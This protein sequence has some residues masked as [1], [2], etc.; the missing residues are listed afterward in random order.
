MIMV[1][2]LVTILLIL[3]IILIIYSLIKWF[4][5][6]S[7]AKKALQERKKLYE[8]KTLDEVDQKKFLE[9]T[10]NKSN[11]DMNQTKEGLLTSNTKM[12]QDNYAVSEIE[13]NY[14]PTT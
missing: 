4:I 14:N 9:N 6:K 2:V 10:M 7:G 11:P 5:E 13:P 1:T 12:Y 3:T 8:E